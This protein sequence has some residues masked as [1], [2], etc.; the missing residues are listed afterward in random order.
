MRPLRFNPSPAA[1]LTLT[2]GR[3]LRDATITS[4]S[5]TSVTVRHAG[6]LVSVPKAQLP[7]ELQSKYPVAPQES[8]ARSQES[9]EQKTARIAKMRAD[10]QARIAKAKAARA[11][12]EADLAANPE[13]QL[14]EV[15][16]L[17]E[18]H[19]SPL[20]VEYNLPGE[21]KREQVKPSFDTWSKKTSM[22]HG[23]IARLDARLSGTSMS[24]ATL[25]I[26][27]DGAE[28]RRTTIRG[29]DRVDMAWN[30]FDGEQPEI[31][32]NGEHSAA[33]RT[34][35]KDP[36]FTATR[37]GNA[38]VRIKNPNPKFIIPDDWKP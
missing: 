7:A 20:N 34:T 13:A 11:E 18:S 10:E 33:G 4:S 6:G 22:Q 31:S 16:Y 24:D 9:A 25:T 2:D 26:K 30:L 37:D 23:S 5:A 17:V 19:N 14:H 15:E 28:V 3:V 27:V 38:T 29:G 36:G 32:K 21:I 12:R 1:D 8:G 35:Y